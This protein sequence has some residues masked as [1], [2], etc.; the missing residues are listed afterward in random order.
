MCGMCG[1]RP[2]SLVVH[3]SSIGNGNDNGL[4]LEYRVSSFAIHTF[5]TGWVVGR[6]HTLH[7]GRVG[8]LLC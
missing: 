8:V 6:V 3:C 5:H 7:T 2:V 1:G 4:G